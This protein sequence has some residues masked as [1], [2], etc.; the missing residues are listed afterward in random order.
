MGD[1][2]RCKLCGNTKGLHAISETEWLCKWI[3]GCEH[4]QYK[5][6]AQLSSAVE[7]L[8]SEVHRYLQN[9]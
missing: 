3:P 6:E 9:F 1:Q 7:V 2:P 8:A 4:R 5:Q